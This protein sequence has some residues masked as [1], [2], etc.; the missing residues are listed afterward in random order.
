MRWKSYWNPE[1]GDIRYKEKFLLFPK[2]I[3]DEGRW[4]EK[5]RY[6]QEYGKNYNRNG[7]GELYYNYQWVDV[8]WIDK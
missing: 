7:Y 6:K 2:I 3:N 5:A 4:L 1:V 8:E